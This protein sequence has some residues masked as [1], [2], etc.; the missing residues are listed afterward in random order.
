MIENQIN[1]IRIPTHIG[2]EMEKRNS[3]PK[4]KS[5]NMTLGLKLK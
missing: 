3:I 5:P 2:L 4:T 1:K